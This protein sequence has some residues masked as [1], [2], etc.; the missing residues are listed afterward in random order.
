M[1]EPIS[2]GVNCITFGYFNCKENVRELMVDYNITNSTI[3]KIILSLKSILYA[4]IT[5]ICTVKLISCDTLLHTELSIT[6]ADNVYTVSA[7][8]QVYKLLCSI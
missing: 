3:H 1:S 4:L 5:S 8:C 2:K 7:L 6:E